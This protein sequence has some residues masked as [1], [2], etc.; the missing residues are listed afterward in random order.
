[1]LG[2]FE[3]MSR[4]G[5]GRRE[6]SKRD[7]VD[8]ASGLSPGDNVGGFPASEGHTYALIQVGNH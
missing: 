4:P 3:E 2:E 8:R 6:D 1:M 5:S 7:K